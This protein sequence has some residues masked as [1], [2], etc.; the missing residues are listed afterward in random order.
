M[1][2][3][4]VNAVVSLDGAGHI[5]HF[6]PAA[7]RTFGYTAD[8]VLGRS[9]LLFLPERW[10]TQYRLQIDRLLSD[11]VAQNAGRTLELTGRRHDG[12]EFPLELC[13]VTWRIEPESLYTVIARD[14]TERKRVENDR[15]IL[16]AR[17]E[18]MAR[19]DELTG[20]PNRRAWDEE[21]RREIA[22]AAR[23]F[24]PL[25]LVLLDIDHF[26][27][28]NDTRGHQAGDALLKEAATSWRMLLRVTDFIA[29]YGGDEFLVLLPDCPRDEALAVVERLRGIMPG[30]QTASAG[31]TFWSE[32]LTAEALVERADKV[33]YEAK[34][35]GR[36]RVAVG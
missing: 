18:A 25:C 32:G 7:E 35:G 23:R 16:L 2:S 24:Y 33:L 31:L 14:I 15:E 30:D 4:S 36:D 27:E 20:L 3:A 19:T 8:E 11:E 9:F 6:N 13:L 1:Q 17:V 22:R 28:F 26:K 29:R 10:H 12:K 5:T 21:L 34:R